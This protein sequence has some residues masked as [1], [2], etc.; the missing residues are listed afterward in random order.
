LKEVVGVSPQDKSGDMNFAGKKTWR[1]GIGKGASNLY[2][3]GNDTFF[4]FGMGER[5]NQ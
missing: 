3:K 2:M 4:I 1:A 5:G